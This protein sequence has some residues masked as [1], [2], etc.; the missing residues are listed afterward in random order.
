MYSALFRLLPGNFV[1][2][3]LQVVV[4]LMVAVAFLFLFAFPF[5]ET[6]IQEDPSVNG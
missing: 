5:V 1:F 2:K 4:M 6:L 3:I